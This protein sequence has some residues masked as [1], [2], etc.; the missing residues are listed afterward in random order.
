[1]AIDKM[2]KRNVYKYI[3]IYQC[4]LISIF[5][6]LLLA[7]T[8]DRLEIDRAASSPHFVSLPYT[9]SQ[10]KE[11]GKISYLPYIY[12]RVL[13]VCK[14]KYRIENGVGTPNTIAPTESHVMASVTVC[15]DIKE[16]RD[17]ERP[18]IPGACLPNLMT[19]ALNTTVQRQRPKGALAHKTA[20]TSGVDVEQ[21]ENGKSDDES[22]AV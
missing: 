8:T 10:Y 22:T 14:T 20:A 12:R 13:Y 16:K 3:Y 18:E 2:K 7:P 19:Q 9:Q 11:K 6:S 15:I 4:R 21:R 5:I 17:H 1:M